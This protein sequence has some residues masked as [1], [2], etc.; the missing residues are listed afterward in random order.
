MDRLDRLQRR[1]PVAGFPIAVVYK[2]VDDTGPFLAALITYYAFVSL[3]PLLLLSTTILGFVLAGNPELQEQVLDSALS[4][5]PV[6]GEQLGDPQ[7]LG[8]GTV[9]VVIGVLGALYGGLGVAQAVQHMMNTAWTVPR[10]DRPNPI[11]ARGRSLLLLATA[12]VAVLG[13]TALSTIGTGGAGSFGGLVRVL[14]LVAS[15]L[16]NAVVFTFVFRLA[17]TRK[18]S[19]RDVLPGALI[20]AV[21]WQL[22]QTFG[23]SYVSRVMDSASAVNGVFALVLGLLAFLYLAAVAG[24]LCVEINVVRVDRLYPRALLTPFTDAVQLTPGDRRSYTGKAKAERLKGFET[25]HVTFDQPD[26]DGDPPR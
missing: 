16:I 18:L 15:V 17:T 3:F 1:H 12:G 25:V 11:L 7:G 5:L 2:Y 13:T 10:N 14:V 24:V 20:A 26:R 8:G 4:Q 6:V 22:L 9:G 23:V 21:L 19:V